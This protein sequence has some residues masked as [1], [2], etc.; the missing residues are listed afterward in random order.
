MPH[1]SGWIRCLFDKRHEDLALGHNNEDA[2]D[3]QFLPVLPKTGAC[4]QA[5]DRAAKCTPVPRG[6]R[7]KFD[8]A[9]GS[10]VAGTS[11]VD[12]AAR[13]SA[14]E[15]SCSLQLSAD[16][17]NNSDSLRTE[18]LLAPTVFLARLPAY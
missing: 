17:L 4:G 14:L 12:L 5:S 6:V 18:S 13:E 1:S 16:E 10:V 11:G 7:D 2:R 3:A 9:S 8:L 15:G